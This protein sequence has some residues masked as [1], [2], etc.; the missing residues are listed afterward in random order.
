MKNKN[1]EGNQKKKTLN[2]SK[3]RKGLSKVKETMVGRKK[4]ME[5]RKGNDGG[6]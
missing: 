4:P 3:K 6:K 2:G 5:G 1:A